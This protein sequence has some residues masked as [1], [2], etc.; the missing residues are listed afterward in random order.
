MNLAAVITAAGSGSRLGRDLPKALVPIDGVSL[1]RWAASY[2]ASVTDRIVVTAP[3]DAIDDFVAALDGVAARVSVVPG[4]SSRQDSVAV[5][6]AELADLSDDDAV[7]V[8]DAARPFMPVAVFGRLLEAI[9][10]HDAAIPVLAVVDTIV[11]GVGGEVEYLDRDRLGAVQTPQAFRIGAVRD[12]HKRAAADG[13]VATDDASLV[14]HYGY[15][16]ATVEG[17]PLG[18][19]ITYPEDLEAFER[20]F[21]SR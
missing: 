15:R 3:A 13:I 10:H 11:S 20:R 1:V 17:D 2:L 7:L 8:H 19:K 16:L 5:G 14:L 4:G 18:R 6:L 9:E 21:S 12:A